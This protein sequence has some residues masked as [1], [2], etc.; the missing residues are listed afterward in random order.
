LEPQFKQNDQRKLQEALISYSR[1]ESIRRT[2]ATSTIR[3]DPVEDADLACLEVSDLGRKKDRP[4][5]AV[6]DFDGDEDDHTAHCPQNGI[7]T[8]FA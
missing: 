1:C 2:E 3:N 8:A 7:V 4:Q 5:G 6:D